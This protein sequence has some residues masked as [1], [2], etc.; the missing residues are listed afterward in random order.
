[1][2]SDEPTFVACHVTL[3]LSI[4]ESARRDIVVAISSTIILHLLF[5]RSDTHPVTQITAHI[6]QLIV[7]Y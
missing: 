7:L 4:A 1:M 2:R 5:S 3:E 6:T